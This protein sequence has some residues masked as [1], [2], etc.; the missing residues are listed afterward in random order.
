VRLQ[1]RYFFGNLI[2]FAIYALI[3]I[4]VPTYLV[5][6]DVGKISDQMWALL[7]QKHRR[8]V[9]DQEILVKNIY[10][11][12]EDSLRGF[13]YLDMESELP[14]DDNELISMG[15]RLLRASPDVGMV[16]YHNTKTG[17]EVTLSTSEAPLFVIRALPFFEGGIVGVMNNDDTGE[18]SALFYGLP[19]SEQ[20]EGKKLYSVFPFQ[21]ALEAHPDQKAKI[22][23]LRDELVDILQFDL[24]RIDPKKF[25]LFNSRMTWAIKIFLAE[26]LAEA[27]TESIGIASLNEAG[28]GHLI[29]K[30]DIVHSKLLFND[31]AFYGEERPS[32]EVPITQEAGFILDRDLENFYLVQTLKKGDVYLSLGS[33]LDALV[34]EVAQWTDKDMVIL[35]EGKV[36]RAFDDQGVEAPPETIELLNNLDTFQHAS[37]I[38]ILQNRTYLYAD[39]LH[40]ANFPISLY[41]L[42]EVGGAD[43]TTR[44]TSEL[45]GRLSWKISL[46]LLLISLIVIGLM[47]YLL[48][49][50]VVKHVIRPV[51]KLAVATG[52]V[53]QGKYGEVELEEMKGRTD[54]IALLNRSFGEMVSG[55]RDKEK[56]RSVL[57]K[58]VSKDVAAEI[59]RSKIHLGGEERKVTT[60][61]GDIRG[62]T[63][64]SENMTPQET[65]QLLND[66]MTRITYIIEEQGGVIDKF[67]GDE[68]MALFGAPTF[69]EEDAKNAVSAAVLVIQAVNKW[70]EERVKEGLHRVEM[71]FGINTGIVLAGNMG[72]EDRLNYTVLGSEVNLA[73]RLCS[74]AKKGEVLISENTFND[75]G[76]QDAFT[77]EPLPPVELKGISKPVLVYKVIDFK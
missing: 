41:Q 17:K 49:R 28:E 30:E 29:L 13:L 43:T 5:M 55:L 64:M 2:L 6:N 34:K 66:C 26:H 15:I 9:R 58:V 16:Q 36:V 72:A 8:L 1:T 75:P 39:L 54:E 68:I 4:I 14:E 74:A 60:F 32:G 46:Q 31:Q 11:R 47:Q 61:F 33:S 42:A 53:V 70:N 25:E 67:V 38:F 21:K 7:L 12:K 76:I 59:L 73:A 22:E 63:R 10:E 48:G 65:V 3:V 18:E 45:S 71:G 56:I 69:R 50:L 20:K 37:G 57:D 23:Q 27:D 62:F 51:E 77:I 52:L 35:I 19:L 24:K 44:L 40:I